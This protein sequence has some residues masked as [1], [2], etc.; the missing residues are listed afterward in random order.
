MYLA[1]LLFHMS[2]SQSR[3]TEACPSA[4]PHASACAHGAN[5]PRRASNCTSLRVAHAALVV[6]ASRATLLLVRHEMP[7]RSLATPPP[8][9][10]SLTNRASATRHGLLVHRRNIHCTS[11]VIPHARHLLSPP[12]SHAAGALCACAQQ[13]ACASHWLPPPTAWR[14]PSPPPQRS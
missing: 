10:C 11:A 4:H 5:T 8:A 14:F 3:P 1:V 13:L 7:C 6:C 9:C 12:F 2:P